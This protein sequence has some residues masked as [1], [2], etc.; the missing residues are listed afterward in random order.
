M[1]TLGSTLL[2]AAL[3]VM[4]ASAAAETSDGAPRAVAPAGERRAD[5]ATVQRAAGL[6]TRMAI[7]SDHVQVW[8]RDAR[9]KAKRGRAACLDDKL[10]QLHAA[11]RLAQADARAIAEAED[12]AHRMVRLKTLHASAKKLYVAAGECGKKVSR[13][14][15]MRTTYQV[16]VYRP[17]LPGEPGDLPRSSQT[18]RKRKS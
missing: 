9:G 8:L 16:K 13:R 14:V 11:E 15:R 10:S 1:K 3:V 6:V 4:G 17:S 5:H 7:Y 18:T 12:G 2:C